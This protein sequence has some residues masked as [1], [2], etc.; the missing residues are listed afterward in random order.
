MRWSAFRRRSGEAGL[1]GWLAKKIREI[2]ATVS[3]PVMAKCAL[4]ILRRRKF[5]RS[6]ASITST[7]PK[8]SRC[9]RSSSR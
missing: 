2:M 3:I 7:N 9:G 5:C 6:S 4:D 1:R 8:C